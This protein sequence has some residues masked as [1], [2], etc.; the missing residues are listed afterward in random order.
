MSSNKNHSGNEKK[1]RQFKSIFGKITE[2]W[3]EMQSE[4]NEP[5]EKGKEILRD[6]RAREKNAFKEYKY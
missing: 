4:K 6:V 2:Y 3:I 1:T 5:Q